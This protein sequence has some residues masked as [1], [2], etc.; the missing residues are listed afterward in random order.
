[1]VDRNASSFS[2]GTFSSAWNE[3]WALKFGGVCLGGFP[4]G[5]GLSLEI[6]ECLMFQVSISNSV[7]N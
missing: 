4:N 3:K 1:M 6:M 5:L 7:W 2:P